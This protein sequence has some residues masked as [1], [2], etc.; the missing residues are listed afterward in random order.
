MHERQRSVLDSFHPGFL[1]AIEPYLNRAATT[2]KPHSSDCRCDRE[3]KIGSY[4]ISLMSLGLWPKDDK[5]ATSSLGDLI[6]EVQRVTAPS[7]KNAMANRAKCSTSCSMDLEHILQDFIQ[8]TQKQITG[9]C[10]TCA[11]AGR[12]SPDSGNC[13]QEIHGSVA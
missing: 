6:H 8:K 7:D 11:K 9:L 10:L 1:E 13:Q 4:F 2:N 5:I 12:I 3:A